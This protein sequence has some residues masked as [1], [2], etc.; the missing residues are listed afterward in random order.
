MKNTVEEWFK[1]NGDNTL[2]LDYDLNENSIVFDLGGY[3]GWFSEQ[4]NNKYKSTIFCFEPIYSYAS[5]IEDKFKNFSNIKVFP[6]A[7]SNK[8]G[9]D[10]ISVNNDA[11]S[12]IIKSGNF[13]EIDCTTID[14]I[15]IK[16]NINNIDLIKINIE[17]VEYE[18]LEYMIQKN[19]ISLCDNIQVQFHK[20]G[21]YLNRYNNIKLELEKTHYLTYRYP[22]VW[23]NWKKI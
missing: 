13:I 10:V 1:N 21:D 9:K 18:L 4:I 2:R 12:I 8:I 17:G 19:L 15:L 6:L 11:S 7:I 5:M 22:F 16:Y 20:I 3:K 23:E 14:D